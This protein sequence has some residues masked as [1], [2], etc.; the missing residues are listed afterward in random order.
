MSP[1]R[2]AQLVAWMLCSLVATRL[3]S[4]AGAVDH[5]R[6]HGEYYQ[7]DGLGFNLTLT[8]H[9]NS[10]FSFTWDGCLGRYAEVKGTY[11]LTA[12]VVELEPEKPLDEES[13]AVLDLRLLPVPWGKRMYLV[14]MD[15][16]PSFLRDINQRDEPRSREGGLFYLRSNDWKKKAE[17]VA[18]LP[19][20]WSSWI[21]PAVIFARI[22]T[23]ISSHRG[24]IHAGAEQH[25]QP[26]M[27]LTAIRPN[28][29]RVAVKVIEV[30]T[31]ES[32]VE[33][34][35]G[36]ALRRGWRVTSWP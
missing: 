30:T 11:T 3:P 15:A 2:T 28:G 34:I 16:L 35:N 27:L 1:R 19:E 20:P 12:G 18:Q 22:E 9:E 17:G 21:L 26:G 36:E 7:G 24:R 31:N 14:P 13:R 25:L 29:E 5:G 8:L 23:R 10:E 33:T 6:L 4:L 32:I